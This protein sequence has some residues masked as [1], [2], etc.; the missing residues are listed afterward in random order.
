VKSTGLSEIARRC[1]NVFEVRMTF[2]EFCERYQEPL[3][4]SLGIAQVMSERDV[5]LGQQK[6]SRAYFSRR[7]LSVTLVLVCQVYLSQ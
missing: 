6:V 5:A 1:V 7:T 2:E 3:A 4:Q